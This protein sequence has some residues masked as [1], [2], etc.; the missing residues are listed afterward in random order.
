M[1]L[2]TDYSNILRNRYPGVKPFTSNEN[3]IFFG[4]KDDIENLY[5][6]IFIKQIVILYGKSGYGKSSL[7]NAGIIPK[8]QEEQNC[9]YFSIRFNNFS[10]RNQDENISPSETV[11]RR[12]SQTLNQTTKSTLDQLLYHEN[13]FW[14]WIK[15]NQEKSKNSQFILFFDQFEELFTYTKEQIE[16]FSEQ[17]SQLLYNT[18]P[19]QFR[20]KLTEMDEKN[21]VSDELHDFLYD[22]PDIKVVFSV[23]SDRL[24]LL[25]GLTV[26]HPSI[27]QNC[28]EL[29]SLNRR[30]AEQ[31]IIEPASLPKSSGFISD[32][33]TFKQD[34]IDKILDSISNPQDGKIETATLQ[35]VCKFI[36]DY[37]VF[38]KK[39]KQITND[40]LG[41]ITDIFKQYYENILAKLSLKERNQAQH[42]IEDELIESGRRNPLSDRYIQNKFGLNESLLLKLEQSSLLRKERDASGRLLYEV[43]HDSL[44]SAIEKVAQGR[45]ALEDDEKRNILEQQIEEEKRRNEKLVSLNTKAIYRYKLAIGLSIIALFTAIV[46]VYFYIESKKAVNA[47]VNSEKIANQKAIEVQIALF[48]TK[49]LEAHNLV[50]DAELFISYEK[51]D[52]ALKSLDKAQ[53]M[54]IVK[55]ILPHNIEKE[56]KNLLNIIDNKTLVCKKSIVQ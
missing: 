35:I 51:Y 29:N 1:M 10:E 16:E 20:K 15:T 27:L 9:T 54:L 44:V 19:I 18:I 31:A 2:S 53:K 8:L 43:S 12:L 23:R 30:Q 39:Q 34:A 28:Y 4:R 40:L 14:Y 32:D 37:L 25:N 11:K 47:A 26:R 48:N 45:R 41:N 13:S 42:L 7:I 21:E 17:L 36:E 6:L 52:M 55:F 24:S 33:F 38:E 50:N 5:S 22:K 56:R 3:G 46:A 49:F